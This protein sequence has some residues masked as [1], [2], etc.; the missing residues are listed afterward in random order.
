MC[1]AATCTGVTFTPVRMCNGT[2]SCLAGT[3][4]PAIRTCA[5]RTAPAARRAPA[6]ATATRPTPASAA[7][8]ARN[9]SWRPARRPPSAIRA[10]ANRGSAARAAC[11]GTCR[12]CAPGGHS[13]NLH[14]GP[15]R[16]RSPQPVHRSGHRGLRPGRN[17]QRQ[18]R[19]PALRDGT[20]CVASSC[21]GSTLTP[22]RTCNGTG[23]CQTVTNTSCGAYMC[24]TARDVPD[25]LHGERRLRGAERLHRDLL[26]HG[27]RRVLQARRDERHDG[28]RLVGQRAQRHACSRRN[29]HRDVLDDAHGGDRLGQPD[30]HQQHATAGTSAS[31]PA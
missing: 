21:A 7:A 31:P 22:A 13:R 18:R 10:S 3:P 28:G 16:R 17:L 5:E 26:R 23:T 27:P 30:G 6:T 24:G 2:G 11:T 29:G 12:S 1:A 4:T 19:L 25:D 15:G 14:V 20:T 8:A 9:R